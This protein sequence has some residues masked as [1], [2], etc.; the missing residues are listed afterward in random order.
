M[1]RIQTIVRQVAD[2]VPNQRKPCQ[3]LACGDHLD[4]LK[5]AKPVVCQDEGVE[6]GAHCC[7]VRVDSRD[8]VVSEHEGLE[9]AQLGQLLQPPD[10]VL[11]QVDAL[12]LVVGR[13]QVLQVGDLVAPQVDVEL[14]ERVQ[15]LLRLAH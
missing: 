5:S 4:I 15:V 3:R 14:V 2:E 1:D 10:I 7:E 6:F 13:R 8:F 12:E 11:R 9:P